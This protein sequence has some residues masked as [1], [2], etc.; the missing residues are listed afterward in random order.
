MKIKLQHR[1]GLFISI[2]LALGLLLL[3]YSDPISR[4]NKTFFATG[5]DGLKDYYV[6]NHFLKYDSAYSH[7]S[8]M[9]YPYGEHVM[10]TGNQPSLSFPVKFISD[11]IIDISTYSVGIINISML[12]SILLGVVFLYL[13][14]MHFQLHYFYSAL[15]AIG[16]VF[17]SPQIARM[18]GHFSL[19]YVFV[20]PLILYLLAR[21]D[22]R[23]TYVKSALLG[24]L[25]LWCAGIHV[26]MLG[27][28]SFMVLCYWAY[29]IVFPRN[30][31]SFLSNLKHFSLQFLIPLLVFVLYVALT[32]TIDDRPEYPYGFLVYRAYPE[33]VLLPID[34][35][36]GRFLR[37]FSDYSHVGWE[38]RAYVGIVAVLGF[39]VT[40]GVFFI[41]PIRNKSLPLSL[42]KEQNHLLYL[43][44]GISFLALLY[45][46][47]VPFIFGLE[48]MVDYLGPI[49][50]MRG[51][52]RFSWVF[53]YVLNIFVFYQIFHLKRSLNKFVWYG[54]LAVS[55]TFLWYDAITHTAFWSKTVNN[56][57]P[58]I[59]DT[60]NVLPQNEWL[61][62]VEI[63]EYQ[64]ILPIPYFHIGSENIWI[65]PID[66]I[67]EYTALVS[68]KTGLPSAGVYM[69]RTS[70]S[71]T[72]NLCKLSWEA[73]R[74]P[75]VLKDMHTEKDLLI[76]AASSKNIPSAQKNIL[77]V[78]E[79]LYS[80]EDFDLYRLPYAALVSLFENL[81][82]NTYEQYNKIA[83]HEHGDYHASSPEM[84][85]YVNDFSGKSLGDNNMGGYYMIP[86]NKSLKFQQKK[87][88]IDL[89]LPGDE[90]MQEFV[91][92]FWINNVSKDLL[93]RSV[94][95]IEIQDADGN[96]Y[97]YIT[98]QLFREVAV[99]D[100]DWVMIEKII[101]VE[102]AGDKIRCILQNRLLY[103]DIYT[104]DQIM[105]RNADTEI[106][107]VT[108]SWIMR[109]NRFYHDNSPD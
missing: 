13:L 55:I 103:K 34:M 33:S 53:F 105:I 12:A 93:L 5:G 64:A 95:I 31:C 52:A 72:I 101:N 62:Y 32:D 42:I 106:Y 48:R 38:G 19:S 96:V 15:V 37:H 92:S 26:Y 107:R 46:F 83:L 99:V 9:N 2:I 23:S 65:E 44:F 22:Q 20:I 45:S 36:Y 59:T 11:N 49:K 79:L 39:L 76:V 94:L 40:T 35:P 4:P 74:K 47:G 29:V 51:I 88:F 54:I 66:R 102:E 1:I 87:P 50:Q 56:T 73:Y 91:V 28:Y 10:F 7:S 16:I 100:G 57:I 82:D 89:T 60:S 8:V 6:T 27:F 70:L 68:W 25:M 14:L 108:D 58:A 78:S 63:E 61:Q 3:F 18:G 77:S 30:N 84:N 69:S 71:Q 17:L 85:F 24:V 98:S 80:N 109:N 41:K 81:H 75:Q 90:D 67:D 43:F 97:D 104:I 86:G 21:Y